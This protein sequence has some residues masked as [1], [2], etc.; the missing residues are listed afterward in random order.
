MQK[1]SVFICICR[2]KLSLL[3]LAIYA[4]QLGCFLVA[5][6]YK[7]LGLWRKESFIYA[8]HTRN[9]FS[10]LGWVRLASQAYS[11]LHSSQAKIAM[12]LSFI[13]RHLTSLNP[14]IS[15]IPSKPFMLSRV[16]SGLAFLS[17]SDIWRHLILSYL[18][19]PAS[20]LC[21][22]GSSVALLICKI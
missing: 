17:Y 5:L 21:Y 2:R 4:I 9:N 18:S 10:F 1:R 12:S 3:H 15:I 13:Q 19:F 20:H 22:Q 7:Q 16:Y 11:S 14:F 6:H 8:V